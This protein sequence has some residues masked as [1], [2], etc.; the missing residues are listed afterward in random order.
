M[1]EIEEHVDQFP[2]QTLK[3]FG[4][5]GAEQTLLDAYN[6]DRLHHGW[7]ISGEKGLGK[8]TLAHMFSRF[9]LTRVAEEDAGA[10][11]FG[12]ELPAD[13]ATTIEVA[14]DNPKMAQLL[15]GGHGNIRIISRKYDEKKKKIPKDIGVDQI[16]TLANFFN[17]T[18]S[19]KGWRVAIINSVDQLTINAANA[20]LKM[21]EEPPEKSI[22]LLISNTPGR[23]L[24]TILSRC[25]KLALLK[26]SKNDVS[27]VLVERFPEIDTLEAEAIA[28]MADGSPGRAINY[29]EIDALQIYKDMLA[30]M[31]ELPQ[32]KTS[33][34]HKFAD[35]L[36]T[37]KNEAKFEIFCAHYPQWLSTVAR[38]SAA[39]G[40]LQSVVTGEGAIATKFAD[41]LG[42][43]ELIEQTLY[44]Q[45]QIA[46]TLGLHLDKKQMILSLFESLKTSFNKS[47]IA[48]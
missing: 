4:H 43:K 48:K 28:K 1:A 44:S 35:N 27:T 38:Q 24:P 37:I 7:L 18:P 33:I 25:Q 15:A 3:L 8:A 16:R 30:L 12:D 46:Q 32:L 6:N 39:G 22:L 34:I 40:A 14:E 17:K 10:G 19:Q 5:S 9:L 47:A 11:L 23:L 42:V 21:L 31:A 26:L 13:K 2:S 20:L 36:S 41:K 29:A 45:E